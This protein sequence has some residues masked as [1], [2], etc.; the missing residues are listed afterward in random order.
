MLSITEL[1]QFRIIDFAVF[2]LSL[3]FVGMLILS[4]LLS[5]LFKKLG[6]FIPKRSWLIWTLPLGIITHL[7]IGNY[8][9]MTKRF[10]DINGYYGLKVIIVALVGLGFL[11]IK[12]TDK[13]SIRK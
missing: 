7:I 12:R 13:D 3:A 10:I 5:F 9:L 6:V 8:T 1:R 11:G 4:P 2:D